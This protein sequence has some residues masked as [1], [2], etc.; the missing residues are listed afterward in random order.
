MESDRKSVPTRTIFDSI[1]PWP[2]TREHTEFHPII[3]K[4]VICR[5]NTGLTD[6]WPILDRFRMHRYNKGVSNILLGGLK[7]I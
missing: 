7:V 5:L 6:G 3:S 2:K 1:C 4:I